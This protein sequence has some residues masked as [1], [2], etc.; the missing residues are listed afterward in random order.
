MNSQLSEIIA[1][2]IFL[3]QDL[4]WPTRSLVRYQ[5]T[6]SI[7]FIHTHLFSNDIAHRKEEV[8]RP[9]I[10]ALTLQILQRSHH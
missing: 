6:I 5:L 2:C 4:R 9:L 7:H 3:T 10:C 8:L 1:W